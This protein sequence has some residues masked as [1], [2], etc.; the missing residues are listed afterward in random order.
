MTIHWGNTEPD[1]FEKH[2]NYTG[3][4]KSCHIERAIKLD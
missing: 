4:G 2:D 1:R 3:W